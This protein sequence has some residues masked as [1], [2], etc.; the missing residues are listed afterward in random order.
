MNRS[1]YLKSFKLVGIVAFLFILY[2][3]PSH[4]CIEI[5][6]DFSSNERFS[7][8][9]INPN[10]ET[11][12][13]GGNGPG[14]YSSIQDAI[15]ASTNGDIIFV[16]SGT[17]H[18]NIKI[19]KSVSL[20]GEN[21][22]NTY[23]DGR[24]K[25]DVLYV[26]VDYV[27]I[28]GFTIQNSGNDVM[29][30]DAGIKVHSDH[31][32]IVGNIIKK[33]HNGIYLKSCSYNKISGNNMNNNSDC[34][35]IDDWT[36]H[37]TILENH[38]SNNGYGISCGGIFENRH[39]IFSGNTINYNRVGIYLTGSS[40]NI[41][42]GNTIIGNRYPGIELSS[43]SS[44]NIITG[45][46]ISLNACGISLEF[47]NNI[48]ISNN[49]LIRNYYGIEIENVSDTTIMRN[50]IKDHISWG[51]HLYLYIWQTESNN[52]ILQNNFLNN[53]PDATFIYG[54]DHLSDSFNV[55]WDGNYWNG[56]RLFL[57]PIFGI[58]E[59]WIFNEFLIPF[60]WINIDWHPSRTLYEI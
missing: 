18:E 23:I 54:A 4:S 39:H 28:S 34:V 53:N 32:D 10:L 8:V 46:Y 30:R 45:N 24:G 37:I 9:F 1:N 12:F 33:N 51:L 20:I 5:E 29:G 52:D 27:T 58:K 13:V 19:N 57:K 7:S 35:A 41:I 2:V 26:S 16:Y 25:N 14:N 47:S 55:D 21:K 44:N 60:P 36:H 3:I 22:T 31:N 11:I 59:I 56:T 50:T 48:F 42:S 40:D 38:I 15:N 49:T 17:Y 6:Q 43:S